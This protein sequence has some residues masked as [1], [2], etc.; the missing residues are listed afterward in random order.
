M[1]DQ[2]SNHKPPP[3]IEEAIH[4]EIGNG[5]AFEKSR[6]DFI[7]RIPDP[8][9]QLADLLTIAT[10]IQEPELSVISDRNPEVDIQEN[11]STVPVS[12]TDVNTD[13]GDSL[14]ET[15]VSEISGLQMSSTG[16]QEDISPHEEALDETIGKPQKVGK[17][18]KKATKSIRKKEES[19]EPPE[20]EKSSGSE[21]SLSP[22]TAW[23]KN[24][25]GTDYVHPYEDD[26][27]VGQASGPGKEGI[28]E[29]FADLLAAQGYKDQAREMYLKLMEKYPEKSGFFAAKIEA[30]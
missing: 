21:S 29:T 20:E 8:S 2:K 4:P 18:L 3:S 25:A 22:F 15:P 10:E 1:E 11:E 27:A 28:T 14:V 13:S 26:F 17:R 6:H 16:E 23:L 30:L 9:I 5:A 7:L 24:L 19:Q 12:T